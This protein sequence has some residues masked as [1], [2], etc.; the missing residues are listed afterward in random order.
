MLPAGTKVSLR[1]GIFADNLSKGQ[2]LKWQTRTDSAL[3]GANLSI[4][5]ISGGM[6]LG[7]M[8]ENFVPLR[9]EG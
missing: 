2:F 9:E 1:V 3:N 8:S 7:G 6:Q 4:H 5:E